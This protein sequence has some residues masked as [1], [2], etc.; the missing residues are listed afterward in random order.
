MT[1]L[2]RKH[3]ELL[4]FQVFQKRTSFVPAGEVSQPDPPEPDICVRSGDILIGVELTELVTNRRVRA[5]E[6]EQDGIIAAA[7]QLYERQNLPCL[8]VDFYWKEGPVV[9]KADRGQLSAFLSEIVASH[10]PRL[11]AE[12]ILDATSEATERFEH[13][14]FDRIWLTRVIEFDE[15]LWDSPRS[16]WVSRVGPELVQARIDAKNARPS[17]Y[18][19]PYT[20]RWLVITSD[21][22]RPSSGFDLTPGVL[23]SVYDSAFDRVFLAVFSM[24]GIHELKIARL[25]A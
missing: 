19:V 7:Q 13:R 18:R 24:G 25:A 22:A 12:A 16:W 8:G 21:G 14:L 4:R 17:E 1:R 5:Q 10:V 11:G 2:H 3:A 15:N 23:S 9:N 6:S 20:Q